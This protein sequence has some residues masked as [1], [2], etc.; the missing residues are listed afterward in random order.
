MIHFDPVPVVL[1]GEVTFARPRSAVEARLASQAFKIQWGY[2][3]GDE[4]AEALAPFK[5]Q[6]VNGRPIETSPRVL[7]ELALHGEF[8]LSEVYRELFS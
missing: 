6:L 4:P 2:V 7:D 5:G 8:D 3:H 1:D